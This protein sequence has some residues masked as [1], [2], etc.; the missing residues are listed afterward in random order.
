[1]LALQGLTANNATFARNPVETKP[2]AVVRAQV[3]KKPEKARAKTSRIEGLIERDKYKAPHGMRR[4]E[5]RDLVLLLKGSLKIG[6]GARK[7]GR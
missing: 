4:G 3:Q 1:M 5:R 7:I 2:S 6:I